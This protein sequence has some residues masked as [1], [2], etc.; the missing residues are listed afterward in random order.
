MFFQTC[1][2]EAV[3]KLVLH[4]TI[5]VVLEV[6]VPPK[7]LGILV[8]VSFKTGATIFTVTLE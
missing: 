2:I 4:L 7:V 3:K 1:Y 5:L 8:A 6:S